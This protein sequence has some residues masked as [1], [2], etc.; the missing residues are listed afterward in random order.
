MISRI[1]NSCFP[2]TSKNQILTYLVNQSKRS[3]NT[4]QE[5]F[6]YSFNTDRKTLSA[7]EDEKFKF[8]KIVKFNRG[9]VYKFSKNNCLE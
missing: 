3:A 7:D 4:F 5:Y 6:H 2:S 1:N 9:R 8:I